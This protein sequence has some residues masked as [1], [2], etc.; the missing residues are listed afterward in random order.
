[1]SFLCHINIKKKKKVDTVVTMP[2]EQTKGTIITVH[3]HIRAF[4]V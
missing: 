4:Y 3:L 2:I 1:M